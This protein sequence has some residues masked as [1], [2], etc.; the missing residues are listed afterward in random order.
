MPILESP[1]NWMSMHNWILLRK[2]SL[3]IGWTVILYANK[4]RSMSAS[5]RVFGRKGALQE[6]K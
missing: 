1:K 4:N 5:N 2:M 3:F 6:M